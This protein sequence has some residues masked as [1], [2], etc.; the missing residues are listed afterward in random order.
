MSAKKAAGIDGIL[1]IADVFDR[2]SGVAKVNVRGQVESLMAGASLVKERFDSEAL[3]RRRAG[4]NA[5]N[6]LLR[7][8]ASKKQTHAGVVSAAMRAWRR[9]NDGEALPQFLDSAQGGIEVVIAPNAWRIAIER[10]GETCKVSIALM[11][12][13]AA[14]LPRKPFSLRQVRNWWLQSKT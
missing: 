1:R 6:R 8:R 10:D 14:R 11:S 5:T 2:L 4:A 3:A 12:G 13:P 9:A 7:A